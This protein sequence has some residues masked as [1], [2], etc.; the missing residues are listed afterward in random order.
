MITLSPQEA[1]RGGEVEYHYRKWGKSKNLVV[2]VPAG[3]RNGQRIRLRGMGA[4][5]K[6]GGEAG[7]L[8]L[9]VRIKRP[10]LRRIRDMFT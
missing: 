7:D 4:L 9:Q 5:G 10:L 1:Q 3:I 2:N 8:Y 6:G